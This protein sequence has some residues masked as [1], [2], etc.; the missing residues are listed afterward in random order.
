VSGDLIR[1]RIPASGGPPP[2]VRLREKISMNSNHGDL[3]AAK[4]AAALFY[5]FVLARVG[6]SAQISL[7][8]AN[9]VTY[10][11][12]DAEADWVAVADL[13]GDG[14]PD[15]VVLN[16][17]T[18]YLCNGYVGVLVGNGDGTFQPAVIYS[19]G[20]ASAT[21]V[22][23]ADVNGD[24]KPDIVVT[25]QYNG[26]VY[27][28]CGLNLCPELTG[29]GVVSVL[30]G[31]GDTTFQ[32]AH[33]YSPGVLYPSAVAVAD[34][35]GDGRPDL[36]VSGCTSSGSSS[37]FGCLPFATVDGVVGVLLGNGDGTFRAAVSYDS[38]GVAPGSLA[39]ADVNGDGK[40]DVLT[41]NE[42]TA[43]G[44]PCSGVVGVL[45]GNG[46]GT[47][48]K[49][50]S[51]PS[52][53]SGDYA[54]SVAV[55]DVDGDGKL[56]LVVGDGERNDEGTYAGPNVVGVL[57]GNGDG[58]FRTAVTYLTGGV[59][60]ASVA[61]A[62]VNEDGK[63]DIVVADGGTPYITPSLVSVLLGN[64]DGTFQPTVNYSSAALIATSVAVADVNRDGKPD[65]VLV[66][67]CGSSGPCG[68][69]FSA[70]GVFINNGVGVARTTTTLTS[71]PNPIFGQ[72]VTLT[73][74][75]SNTSSG[76]PTGTVSFY[77]GGVN[78]GTSSLA[79]NGIAML[80]TAGLPEGNNSITAAY[81]G[82]SDFGISASPVLYVTVVGPITVPL[83]NTLSFPNQKLETSSTP[84]IVQLTNTGTAGLAISSV[85]V[86]GANPGDFT[87]TNNCGAVI[88]VGNSCQISLTFAP[89]NYGTGSAT[90]TIT[91]NA[92]GSPQSVTLTGIAN[93]P[94]VHFVGVGSSAMFDG[95]ALAAYNDMIIGN[96]LNA[97]A[98]VGDCPVDN[99]CVAR[100]WTSQ[101]GSAAGSAYCYDTRTNTAL[102]SPV[103]QNGSLWIVWVEDVTAGTALDA[104]VYLSVD[105]TVGIRCFLARPQA[106]LV[107]TAGEGTAGANTILSTL[108]AN[109]TLDTPLDA[110]ILNLVN[111]PSGIPFT[112]AMTD[113]RPED[114][115]LA[116]YR[117]LGSTR[118]GSG[119]PGDT[120]PETAGSYGPPYWD[121]YSFALGYGN[122][123]A[124][125]EA[126]STG[127]GSLIHSGEPGSGQS[128]QPVLYGLPGL[129]DPLSGETVSNTIQV[130]PVG[131]S[132]II[133][134]VN[135]SNPD[136]FGQ[137][138]ASYVTGEG[139][140]YG[141]GL[142]RCQPD[143]T[144]QPAGY[145]SDG[146]YYVRNVWDQHPW[147][148]QANK[149]PN[150]NFPTS[151]PCSIATNHG[152]PE[153]HVP[154]RPLGNL[155]SGGDCEGDNAAF[156]WPLSPETHGLRAQVPNRQVF[157]ITLFPRDPLSGAYNTTEFSVIRRYGTPDGSNGGAGTSP[158]S[159]GRPPYI[160][161]ESNVVQ[162]GD[163][164]LHKQ[165]A[166]D[167]GEVNPAN[168]GYRIRAVGSGES[169]FG[170][171]APNTIHGDGLQFTADSLAYAY[172]SFSSFS[173]LA[174][175]P[176]YG[177][178]MVD[179]IDPLFDNYENAFG[180][181]SNV[182]GEP[183]CEGTGVPG[184]L[185]PL[186]LPY[187]TAANPGQPA[188]PTQPLTWGEFPTCSPGGSG[189]AA[190]AIW[191]TN[192]S[193]P[194]LRDG[195][196]PAWSELR[197]IC[198]TAAANCT[199]AV[200]PLG[201]EALLQHLQDD[202]HNNAAGSVANFLPFSDDHSF[203]VGGYGDVAFVR[204]H[205][206]FVAANDA[207][208]QP[209]LTPFPF[210][211]PTTTHES[212]VQVVFACNGGVP[213]NGPTPV[214]ECGGDVGGAIVPA[215]TAAAT[216][217][218]Q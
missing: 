92:P 45:L 79:S 177:Y 171:G 83:P 194:H 93:P 30:L 37:N 77:V 196:Y 1:V 144:G 58:T 112:A 191:G 197:V 178:L 152:L 96:H 103:N 140:C 106:N 2:Q 150:L 202:I 166:A 114:A 56:D 186:A 206:S 17:C 12:G 61:V 167:F 133:F 46:D 84:Q 19:S 119:N 174:A 135:R 130:F 67:A 64:G 44:T 168:E 16:R 49:A 39:V 165:C 7:S 26:Y 29:T 91:D 211:S 94:G 208:L 78:I 36:V 132:P 87:Q 217:N 162:P 215:G 157:P 189:C 55:A 134:A 105:S 43:G 28:S 170:P 60:A 158:D 107:L 108:F 145:V 27:I 147:P 163:S 121:I 89:S 70:I 151:G 179:A 199:A 8:F 104:W 13:N 115:L 122:F 116:T 69:N 6:A 62:D 176:N 57:L 195:T 156:S 34:V 117:A 35:N 65:L 110:A 5:I 138:I 118:D 120:V 142:T 32:A 169:L 75:V 59:D 18:T 111:Q 129:N 153:C 123:N 159:Y 210:T 154:R 9:P 72:T 187:P 184:I 85:Q 188:N 155:F 80:A 164:A 54:V 81:S 201:A 190:S 113:I 204:D 209:G 149:F 102:V 139:N 31:N 82:D 20:G 136:G 198:D 175:S 52:G 172:W 42:C 200:D 95:F 160:S 47:F 48:Q 88:S 10:G 74:T 63:P 137:V 24:G 185:C 97:T 182:Q 15:I 4:L 53:P 40:P 66:D 11:T 180:N 214:Q 192:P 86:T 127:M 68:Q 173:G 203:G 143:N 33:T 131:E 126:A 141:P 128:V 71:S 213:L 100:H 90:L 109:D 25:N 193:F 76:T 98:P 99:T 181:T 161:Q 218:L 23:I 3:R 73:A 124:A 50:V 205:F 125:S 146:S 41:A 14:I 207:A 38:G 212:N 22:A 183:L 21:S 51:Y 101:V 148:A 216:S